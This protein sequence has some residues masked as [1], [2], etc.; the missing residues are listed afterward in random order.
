M[1]ARERVW[2]RDAVCKID[3]QPRHIVQ[4][5]KIRP[6][7]PSNFRGNIIY[8]NSGSLC[9]TPEANK[10]LQTNCTSCEENV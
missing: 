4:H 6:L 2:V 10:M 5:R 8:K 1:R 7:F 3:E 9:S